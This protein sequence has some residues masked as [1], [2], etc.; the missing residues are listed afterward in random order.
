[1]LADVPQ[2]VA[3]EMYLRPLRSARK[4]AGMK[5]PRDLRAWLLATHPFAHVG[6]RRV[7][8]SAVGLSYQRREAPHHAGPRRDTASNLKWSRGWRPRPGHSRSRKKT[9]RLRAVRWITLAG[10]CSAKGRWRICWATKA[11]SRGTT[12][13]DWLIE[14]LPCNWRWDITSLAQE[15]LFSNTCGTKC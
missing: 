15:V 12:A 10:K 5:Q 14:D 2:N 6:P 13:L 8:M 3:D 1:M 9:P 7:G 4:I 11:G